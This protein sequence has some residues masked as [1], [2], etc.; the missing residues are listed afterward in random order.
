M[1]C[2]R[3]AA[4]YFYDMLSHLVR[5]RDVLWCWV[6]ANPSTLP[7]ETIPDPQHTHQRKRKNQGPNLTPQIYSVSRIAC[8]YVL[9]GSSVLKYIVRPGDRPLGLLLVYRWRLFVPGPAMC[10]RMP[11]V[12]VRRLF[13]Q[14][15]L[16]VRVFCLHNEDVRNSCVARN[17]VLIHSS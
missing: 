15:E 5:P 8:C 7:P 3:P 6:T 4:S 2:S 10:L 9:R 17:R 13:F 14:D 11:A 12:V 1:N 16:A